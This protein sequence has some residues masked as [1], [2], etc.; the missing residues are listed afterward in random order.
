ML[1]DCANDAGEVIDAHRLFRI[2]AAEFVNDLQSAALQAV[3]RVMPLVRLQLDVVFGKLDARYAEFL[4]MRNH[5]IELTA[6]PR[7]FEQDAARERFDAGVEVQG[8]SAL[9]NA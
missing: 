6:L 3:Y 8:R 9:Q 1:A 7:I 5:V 2:L 4:Q